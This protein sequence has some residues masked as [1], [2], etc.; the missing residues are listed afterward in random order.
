MSA[1]FDNLVDFSGSEFREDLNLSGARFERSFIFNNATTVA[2][3][4]TDFQSSLF[5]ESADFGSTTFG[6]NVSFEGAAFNH[7]A[8]FAQASFTREAWFRAVEF[9]SAVDFSGAQLWLARFDHARFAHE[10]DFISTRFGPDPLQRGT[11][12]LC[13]NGVPVWTTFCGTRF[14][15][16]AIFLGAL[17]HGVTFSLA[18]AVGDLD[19]AAAHF[20]GDETC[21]TGR[22]DFSTTQLLGRVTFRGAQFNCVA[23]FDQAFVHT[24]DLTGANLRTLWLP[25]QSE[26]PRPGELGSIGTLH[27]E[28]DDI[29]KVEAA[30]QLESRSA[31]IRTLE[32]V[33]VSAR[34]AGDLDT[35]NDARIKRLSLIR[36]SRSLI[37]RALDWV[38]WWGLLGY[39]VQ[40]V[41]QAL[42]I[43]LALLVAVIL[44][45]AFRSP[46]GVYSAANQGSTRPAVGGKRHAGVFL[47]E[48][49][50]RVRNWLGCLWRHIEDTLGVVFRLR[51]P[52]AGGPLVEYLVFK[53]LI[54]VLIVNIGNVWP[55]FRELLEGVV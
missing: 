17:F 21:S 35:A 28:V 50:P 49:P 37:P 41:H 2:N 40:P 18:R 26:V 14:D 11:T 16:G 6:G 51:P 22:A 54:V 42:A 13:S 47:R 10:A 5:A 36:D 34:A 9:R 55:P 7:S 53:F 30:N 33:E 45:I 31:R 23:N 8:N 48:L 20:L 46:P 3:H 24:L 32:L 27:L 38:F 15:A 25:K 12:H 19:F 52:E 4:R 43:A 44:R 29:H 1:K 39:L